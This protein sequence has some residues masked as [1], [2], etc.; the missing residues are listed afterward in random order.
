VNNDQTEYQS[1]AGQSTSK[2]LSMEATTPPADV[3]GY[4]LNQFLGA[5]AFG[6]VWV[7]R[8][9]NTGRDVAVK[10]YLHRGG[11][12]WSLLS[13]E[14]KNLVQMSADRYVVQV[15]E[16]GW[17]AD[18]P[19]YV[20]ELVSGGSLEDLLQTRRQLPVAEAVEMFRKICTGLNRCHAK[21][22]LH[23]D[24]KPA[25]ILL[26]DENEP[27]L[28]DFGQSRLSSDQTPAL[29]TLFYMAPEQANLD[30]TPDASWDV[31]A[32]GAIMFRMLAGQA[33]YR[34]DKI[35]KQLDTAGSLPKRLERY[36]EAI[37][38][39]PPPNEHLQRGDV[40]R[41]LGRIVSKCLA[42]EP[43]D[44]YANVQQ[45]LEDLNRRD[46]SHSRRPLMLL[47]IVGP[48][49]VL[50]ATSFFGAR[51]IRQAE[52]GTKEMLRTEA[53]GSNELVA[54]LA[55]RTL[56]S[57]IERYFELARDEA[58]RPEFVVQLK[59]TLQTAEVQQAL[60]DIVAMKTPI[61]SFGSTGAR[62]RLL[63]APSRIALDKLL[64]ERLARYGPS[65]QRLRR[66]RLATM[67]VTDAAGT[68]VSIAYS[69]Q[70]D[71]DGNS[72]GKNF[73][74]RSYYH[75]GREDL[76]KETTSIGQVE[77]LT[78]THLSAAFP[79]TATRLWKVAVSTPIYLTEDSSKPDAL[80][81]ATINLG[82]FELLQSKRGSNQVAVLVEA[83][84]G[85]SQGTI[86]QHP[87]M[88]KRRGAGVKMEGAKYQIPA[89]LMNR[90]LEGGIEDYRDP[91]AAAD[92]GR[93][94]SGP[95]IAAMQPV[96]VPTEVAE[97]A[98][99]WQANDNT[100][101]LVL[102][103]Y[104]LA[105]VIEPVDRMRSGLFWEGAAA[106]ASILTV[107]LT[108]WFFVGR[109]GNA[110]AEPHDDDESRHVGNI[111]TISVR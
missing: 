68:I 58:A 76:S 78:S 34:Q 73:C 104:R 108:L 100:D 84:E 24:V 71:R 55:A 77:P 35:V 47:G 13:R 1:A 41:T 12:N 39:S 53:F 72:A 27:R 29:G 83:R 60:D 10:F 70:I 89:P 66:P 93:L 7:G 50:L 61:A 32:V 49:L 17:D 3:P 69:E 23:C 82:D 36:R 80:F 86:L 8:D 46:E 20:M 101:L 57:E 102:V 42:V 54:A 14:V 33:P 51:S 56:E 110:D 43:E 16:V 28:A 105:K 6:Q 107:T 75:G 40:D 63:D 91:L 85:P 92:D 9:L 99:P 64:A 2:K 88:D 52:Q 74:Y 5:G 111:E 18:P 67:F 62:D 109:V 106:I 21:G 97:D 79:S 94:Y 65:D 44:R 26:G 22:V 19:Y 25:N 103:Q 95:W 15:L 98:R 87:L 45:I 37:A 48:L 81:V 11:V 59:E 4:R 96:S 30:S 38:A 31:Y 90:L